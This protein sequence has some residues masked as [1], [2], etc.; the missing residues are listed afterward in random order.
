MEIP[1]YLEVKT[2]DSKAFQDLVRLAKVIFKMTFA[3][4]V[5]EDQMQAYLDNS[6]SEG[7]MGL[8]VMNPEAYFFLVLLNGQAIGYFKLNTGSAQTESRPEDQMEIQRF[9]LHPAYHGTGISA[10]MMQTIENLSLLQGKA[11]LWLGVAEDN[12]PAVRFYTKQGFVQKGLHPF[13]F[14]G[15][16]QWD[17]CM[18]KDLAQYKQGL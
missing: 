5:S 7:Q 14:A 6:L 17:L 4:T 11:L 2:P 12:L 13:D 1:E 15:E 8:E 10:H 3:H 9:Y 18:E 16:I